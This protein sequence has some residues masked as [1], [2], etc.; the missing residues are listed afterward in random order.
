MQKMRRSDRQ[1][2]NEQALAV[3]DKGVYGILCTN[4]VDG[5]PYGVPVNYAREGEKIYF[6]CALEGK[7]LLNLEACAKA[8][9]VVVGEN[10]VLSEDFA[11]SYESV[12][13]FGTV[14][15]VEE[16]ADKVHAL[17]ALVKKYSPEFEEQGRAYA[18][19]AVAATKV[20][21]MSIEHLT[22]KERQA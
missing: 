20:L 9:L 11:M 6:H 19:R 17:M 8:S 4:G 1:V 18:D 2:T 10:E 3:L 12:M 7:K 22:G 21:C 16:Q 14:E 13:A 15:I 5:Y